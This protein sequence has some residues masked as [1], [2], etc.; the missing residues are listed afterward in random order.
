MKFLLFDKALS[1]KHNRKPALLVFKSPSE[2]VL[3][4]SKEFIV[5]YSEVLIELHT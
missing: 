5:M 1:G 4:S 3:Q 2:K